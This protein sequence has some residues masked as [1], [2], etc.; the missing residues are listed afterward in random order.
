MSP[1][2]ERTKQSPLQRQHFTLYLPFF[3][4]VAA[5]SVHGKHHISKY[6]GHMGEKAVALHIWK[7]A[8]HIPLS[9]ETRNINRTQ[10]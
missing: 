2:E 8:G 6:A 4:F 3:D 7:F 9:K 5:E 1:S 10:R